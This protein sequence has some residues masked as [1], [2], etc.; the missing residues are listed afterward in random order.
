MRICLTICSLLLVLALPAAVGAQDPAED[1]PITAQTWAITDLDAE[2]GDEAEPT[3]AI[4]LSLDDG[5]VAPLVQQDFSQTQGVMSPDGGWLA[6]VSNE[7]GV[8]EVVVRP[9]T[10]AA[11]STMPTAGPATVVSRG[12]GNAPR[13]RRGNGSE[14]F[15]Q[16][17]AGGVMAVSI[18]PRQIGRPVELFR[19]PGLL[20]YWDVAADGRFLVAVPVTPEV[21]PLAAVVN[22]QAELSR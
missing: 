6:Y 17:P 15:Y 7:S 4:F 20:P 11:G 22:W 18:S 5:A 2:E 19:V 12:G 13:W 10:T 1:L 16:S 8:N 21:P 14:L 3:H 9:L